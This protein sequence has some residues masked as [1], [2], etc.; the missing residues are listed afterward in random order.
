MI[1]MIFVSAMIS[2]WDK[3]CSGEFQ[4]ILVANFNFYTR[5][6]SIYTRGEFQFIHAA[7]EITHMKYKILLHGIG[8]YLIQ[9]YYL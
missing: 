5:R 6:I 4:F 1:Q 9:N 2:D 7:A 8:N 3:I